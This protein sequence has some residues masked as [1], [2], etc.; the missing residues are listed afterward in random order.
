MRK[1][2]LWNKTETT[3]FEFTDSILVVES[4]GLGITFKPIENDGKISKLKA[5]HPTIELKIVFGA[6]AN[7]YEDHKSLVDFIALNGNK[8]FVL[9]YQFDGN[10]RFVDVW[11]VN[12]PKEDKDTY[13]TINAKLSLRR[14]S[15]WYVKENITVNT[16]P[17]TGQISNEIFEDTNAI[18]TISGA[19]TSGL[20]ISTSMDGVVYNKIQL[21]DTLTATQ[22]L[23]INGEEKSV[24]LDDDGV[25]S[26][27]YNMVYKLYNTFLVNKTG[28][29]KIWISGGSA[30]SVTITRKKMVFS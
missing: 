30:S 28:I 25:E 20:A 2:I 23:T 6:G 15:H 18:L 19:T 7:A 10:T 26:N 8:Q 12:L 5:S 21:V 27:G 3:S 1:F 13:Q 24:T 22:T 9:E 14:I 16:N 17:E 11:I 29:S 4:K